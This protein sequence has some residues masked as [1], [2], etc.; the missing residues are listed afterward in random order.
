[1]SQSGRTFTNNGPGGFIQTITGN[2]GPAIFPTGGNVNI[3][4]VNNITTT[5]VA[6]STLNISV[7]GTVDHSLLLGNAS[8]SINSLGVATDG[9]L[10]IGSTGADPVLSTLT[11]GTGISITNGAGSITITNTGGSVAGT[12]AFAYYLLN[13]A[14][15]V[16]VSGTPYQI[17]FDTALVANTDYSSATGFYTAPVTG[18]YQINCTVVITA[19]TGGMIIG[20][21]ILNGSE[22]GAGYTGAYTNPAVT[23]AAVIAAWGDTASFLVPMGA[24]GTVGVQINI[25]GASGAT[26]AGTVSG[27]LFSGYRV[28]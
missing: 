25:I 18:V 5:G 10:P 19:I 1:M 3:V 11:A 12:Q 23:M 17:L 4:G 2:A 8:G 21:T 6:P 13:D 24:G 20:Q 16:T 9:Q 14:V 7:T 26:V 27:C 15:G 22:T 28:A